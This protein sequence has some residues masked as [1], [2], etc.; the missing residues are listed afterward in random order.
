MATFLFNFVL[1]IVPYL[2][3]VYILFLLCVYLKE[4]KFES[5]RLMLLGLLFTLF[6]LVAGRGFI[7]DNHCFPADCQLPS[8][9]MFKDF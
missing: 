4:S 6:S 1:G 5:K 2:L 7:G 8:E 9:E 3:T